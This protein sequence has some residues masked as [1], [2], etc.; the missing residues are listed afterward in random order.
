M[1]VS[2]RYYNDATVCVLEVRLPVFCEDRSLPAVQLKQFD[3][4]SSDL[5]MKVN[6]R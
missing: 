4:S 1:I 2:S 3:V 5:L 6:I